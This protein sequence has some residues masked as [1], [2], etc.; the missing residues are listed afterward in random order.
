MMGINIASSLANAGSVYKLNKASNVE[1]LKLVN[2]LGPQMLEYAALGLVGIVPDVL[3]G[4]FPLYLVTDLETGKSGKNLRFRGINGH[5]LAFN[6]SIGDTLIIK[7]SLVGPLAPMYLQI[8]EMYYY[9]GSEYTEKQNFNTI[10]SFPNLPGGALASAI[11]AITGP[12]SM[13]MRFGQVS[14]VAT[15]GTFNQEMASGGSME[16]PN[17]TKFDMT[18]NAEV[19]LVGAESSQVTTHKNTIGQDVENDD[20]ELITKRRTFNVIT[21]NEIYPRMY[22]E[23]LLRTERHGM[24]QGEIEVDLLLRKYSEQ[25][26]KTRYLYKLAGKESVPGADNK[27]VVDKDKAGID[28][29]LKQGSGIEKKITKLSLLQA[30]SKKLTASKVTEI[31][32]LQRQKFD[33]ID[34]V[35]AARSGSSNLVQEEP[36]TRYSAGEGFT[37]W[38]VVGVNPDDIIDVGAVSLW[39]NGGWRTVGTAF[40]MIFSPSPF[41]TDPLMGRILSAV[42]FGSANAGAAK[43]KVAG[44]SS[45]PPILAHAV[46]ED[47][48]SI[49][50]APHQASSINH[51]SA[52]S[53]SFTQ[54]AAFNQDPSL[55]STTLNGKTG[56]T[57]YNT[58]LVKWKDFLDFMGEDNSVEDIIDVLAATP[59]NKQND[60]ENTIYCGCRLFKITGAVPYNGELTFE[61]PVKCSFRVDLQQSIAG[62]QL[63]IYMAGSSGTEFPVQ[64]GLTYFMGTSAPPTLFMS[65]D[66]HMVHVNKPVKD[67]IYFYFK[68]IELSGEYY[69][70]LGFFFYPLLGV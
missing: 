42:G 54:V 7:F 3:L 40:N 25:P 57:E 65:L 59:I 39:I 9:S 20:W 8:L 35:T 15:Q 17:D 24:A 34:K 60:M 36:R 47:D 19:D 45:E 22:I 64:P 46:N 56:V 11:P 21:K 18:Q 66:D 13:T 44:I 62:E 1:L 38:Q 43:R 29:L 28:K 52:S 67:E 58:P 4:I 10:G 33:L 30:L 37:K 69:H 5:L 27:K 70:V 55:A 6:K 68:S 2:D 53:T 23:H 61:T 50:T 63:T 51:G 26:V 41:A 12:T 14:D 16:L 48:E 31:A 49:P 32:D